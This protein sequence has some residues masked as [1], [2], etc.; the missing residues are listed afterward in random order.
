MKAKFWKRKCDIFC[1]ITITPN[2]DEHALVRDTP[3]NTSV[4]MPVDWRGEQATMHFFGGW[5]QELNPIATR[6]LD[7]PRLSI[8]GNVHIITHIEHRYK[9][10]VRGTH[11]EVM[12]GIENLL[13]DTPPLIFD[14]TLRVPKQDIYAATVNDLFAIRMCL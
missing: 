3:L 8:Y 2:G 10:Q 4:E 12:Y 1:G 9:M 14:A 6:L 11:A 13:L 5:G 7:H